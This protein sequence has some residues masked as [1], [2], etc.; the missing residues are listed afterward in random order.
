MNYPYKYRCDNCNSKIK[1]YKRLSCNGK[2][3]CGKCW[4]KHM[5]E[6]NC[7]KCNNKWD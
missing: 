6:D 1:I 2:R 7:K 5:K 3:V 4:Q